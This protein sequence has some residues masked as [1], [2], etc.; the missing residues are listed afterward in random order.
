ME[1]PSRTGASMG[2]LREEGQ[3]EKRKKGRNINKGI[4]R[5]VWEGQM[6]MKQNG[7][8]EKSVVP[9]GIN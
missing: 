9:R 2:L 5:F 1:R 6:I 8:Y 4:Y 3:A 7:K